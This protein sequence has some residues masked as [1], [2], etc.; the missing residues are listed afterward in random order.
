MRDRERPTTAGRGT[1]AAA[2]APPRHA[3]ADAHFLA[4]MQ[5]Q[6][7]NAA[8]A[9]LLSEANPRAGT[10]TVQRSPASWAG[11]T[12]VADIGTYKGS[13]AFWQ[14]V[15]ALVARYGQL[16]AHDAAGRGAVLDAIE[17]A[18][19]RWQANQAKG[20][21]QSSLDEKKAKALATLAGLIVQERDELRQAAPQ[22]PQAAPQA[23]P[24]RAP[25]FPIPTAAVGIGTGGG[26][27]GTG[28]FIEAMEHTPPLAELGLVRTVQQAKVGAVNQAHCRVTVAGGGTLMTHDGAYRLDTGG[29]D[30][31][32]LILL[33][34]GQAVFYASQSLS[35]DDDAQLGYL[36]AQAY[37]ILGSHAQIDGTV[38]AAGDWVVS[39]GRLTRISNQSGT[40]QPNGPNLA[41]T[42][43][44]LVRS[45][46]VSENAIVTG[47]VTVQQFISKP[48]GFNVDAGK[49]R[50]I[51]TRALSGQLQ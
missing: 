26:K 49:L 20:R 14:P 27:A 22:L 38:I 9:R 18:I 31:R 46:I 43:K 5:H 30:M 23:A 32:Y 34:V 12:A 39:N 51:L 44:L 35:D 6:V 48:D 19:A 3:E 45:G 33:E 24:P 42:L 25:A 40:W 47:D 11:T 8:V 17:G 7:G 41:V 50:T 1:R 36:Q 28:S 13:A 21:W 37:P 29:A 4:R 16:P 10:T 2:G 15:K